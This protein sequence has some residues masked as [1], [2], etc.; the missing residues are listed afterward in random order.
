MSSTAT[1]ALPK[2]AT[3][4]LRSGSTHNEAA[5]PPIVGTQNLMILSKDE[6]FG[7]YYN[8]KGKDK[9]DSYEEMD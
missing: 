7:Q 9:D 2:T 1:L 3:E 6:A 4:D 5:K 8:T